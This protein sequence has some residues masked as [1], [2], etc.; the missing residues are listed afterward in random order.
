[1]DSVREQTL[2][3]KIASGIEELINVGTLR[4]GDRIPSVR[5][6]S[7]QHKVSR[8]TVL[9]A[10]TVLEN[11]RLIE[12]RPRSGFYVRSRLSK[13]SSAPA[14]VNRAPSPQ[15]LD[16][17]PPLMAMIT[18]I[19]NPRF[20]PMGGANPSSEL[21]PGKGF[22]ESSPPSHGGRRVR[23]STMIPFP[24]A[25]V[26]AMRLAAGHSTGDATCNPTISFSQMERPRLYIFLSLPSQSPA[27]RSS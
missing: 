21:L 22:L 4:L 18:D 9:H 1:M 10:Y 14:I 24:D 15:S 20:V 7:R 8:P 23:P 25:R 19:T 12:A 3:L 26:C 5:Q 11:R 13:I 6:L 2:Y 17:F 16:E 27:T